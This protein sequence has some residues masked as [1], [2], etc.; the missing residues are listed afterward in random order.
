MEKKRKHLKII[1]SA[2]FTIYLA[3]LVWIILFKLQFRLSDLDHIRSINL[4][5]FHYSV[6]IGERFHIE[7]VRDNVLIFIPFGIFISMLAPRMKL[8]SKILIIVGTSLALETL[9]YILAI[10]GTDITDLITN[11]AG[12]VFGIAIYALL[13]K[14]VKDKQKTDMVISIIAGVVTVLFLGLISILLISN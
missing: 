12:G 8:Q 11:S 13:L 10:G 4:I 1:G 5:P 2:L 3:L 9:Q 14:A 7:E 6:S